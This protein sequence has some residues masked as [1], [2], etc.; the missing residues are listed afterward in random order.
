MIK[1][2]VNNIDRPSIMNILLYG[3]IYWYASQSGRLKM[4]D[5]DEIDR[6]YLTIEL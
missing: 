3:E 1:F 4:L 6:R 2:Y 5:E